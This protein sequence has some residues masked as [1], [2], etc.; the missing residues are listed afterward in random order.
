[1]AINSLIVRKNINLNKIELSFDET[2]HIFNGKPLYSKRFDKVMS[3][4]TPGIAAVKNREGAFHIN[5]EGNAIYTKRF[6]QTFGYYDDIAAVSDDTGWY[7]INLDGEPIYDERYEWVGNYQEGL[8]PVWLGNGHYKHIRKDGVPA[9]IEEYKYVG[10]FKYGIAV[11]YQENGTARHINKLGHFI[12]Q[13]TFNV[14]GVFHKG[15]AIAKDHRGAFHVDKKGIP[16]YNQRYKWVEPFYNGQAIVSKHN[17]EL[18][19]INEN[20]KTIHQIY[21]QATKKVQLSLKH[22]LMDMLVGYWKIQ[23]LRSIVELNI[24]E[25]IQKGKNTFLELLNA[26]QIP[27]ES[28]KMVIDYLK[29]YDFIEFKSGKYTLKYMGKLLTEDHPESLKYPALMWGAEH[30]RTMAELTSALKEY[31]P[32]FQKLF[33]CPIFTYFNDNPEKGMIFNKAMNSYS[34]DYDNIIKEY[35]FSESKVLMDVGGGTGKLLAKILI[36]NKN[37]EKGILFDLHSVIKNAK[38]TFN[39]LNLK[40]RMEYISGDFFEKIPVKADTIIMSRVLHDWNDKNAKL[41]LKNV[42]SALENEGNLLI[43]EMVVPDNPEFDF[44]ISLNFNLLVNVGGKERTLSEFEDMLRQTS[45]KLIDIKRSIGSIS[46]I[47][48]KKRRNR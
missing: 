16:I 4:H 33:G 7:H 26:S 27:K 1:M 31:K 29:I 30:Y 28:L 14:L 43:L 19:I 35:D 23:I 46:L 17:N 11:V 20:G 12:H 36:H 38:K 10:D 22:Q 44:G 47:I 21:D 13:N 18:L 3:F 32:Q 45:F 24:L 37:I 9:Y 41:I 40:S 39:D 25:L 5:L 6:F 42:N 2:H 15:F 34:F 48:A 8:C